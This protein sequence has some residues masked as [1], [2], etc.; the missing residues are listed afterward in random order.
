MK[1]CRIRSTI[2]CQLSNLVIPLLVDRLGIFCTFYVRP[3]A[4]TSK[5]LLQIAHHMPAEMRLSSVLEA[6]L[7]GRKQLR[8]TYELRHGEHVEL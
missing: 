7:A 5:N 2:E 6:M 1:L 4:D 3:E 8:S